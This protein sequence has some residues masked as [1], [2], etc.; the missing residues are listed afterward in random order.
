MVPEVSPVV[1]GLDVNEFTANERTPSLRN[2]SFAQILAS[3]ER[4]VT[5]TPD[6]PGD[7]PPLELALRNGIKL[8]A[9]FASLALQGG[10]NARL[11]AASFSRLFQVASPPLDRVQ[12]LY[13]LFDEGS[14]REF[15]SA[16]LLSIAGL[17]AADGKRPFRY[18][19]Q[20]IQFAPLAT[21]RMDVTELSDFRGELHVALHGY[22]L[23]G[24]GAQPTAESR[25]RVRRR[26]R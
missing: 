13:A 4:S 22:K 8:N 15:Q 12:F 16:P 23:L 10:A 17:G 1:F 24:S 14:G 26:R 25:G 9:D 6:V 21:I 20:P 5:A 19:A 11:D 3:L 18:F 2:V 7:A